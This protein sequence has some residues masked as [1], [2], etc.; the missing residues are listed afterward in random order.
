V[1]YSGKT[2]DARGKAIAGIAGITFSIYKEQGGGAPL[3][4]ETQN[5]TADAKGNYI[6][7]V[8]AT[9]TDG[10]PLGAC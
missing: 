4:V 5:I 9:K 6:V 7:Q 3:W 1:N 2:V 10:L 8:G